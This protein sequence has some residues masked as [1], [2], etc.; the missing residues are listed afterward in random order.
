MAEVE[1]RGVGT[2][3]ALYAA[4]GWAMA[5]GMVGS[6]QA[7]LQV[8]SVTPQHGCVGVNP[9]M[10]VVMVFTRPL[11]AEA[12]FASSGTFVNAGAAPPGALT[13][14][15][16]LSL[17]S[18][19]RTLFVQLR[20]APES[21][22][23]YSL[24]GARSADGQML[25][26]PSTLAFTTGATMPS[27]SVSGVVTCP[28]SS[29][30]GTF[31]ALY[32]EEPFGGRP[33]GAIA[34]GEQ[35]YVR[36]E[37]AVCAAVVTH[38]GGQYAIDYVPAGTW[39]PLAV[40]DLNGDG[41]LSLFDDAWGFLD[42][43]LDLRPDSLVL[44]EGEACTGVDLTVA[45]VLV[46]VTAREAAQSQ[47]SVARGWAV[48]ANLFFLTGR[49]PDSVGKAWEW[50]G[51]FSSAA[52]NAELSLASV[53]RLAGYAPSPR[54]G[55]RL[56]ALPSDWVDSPVVLDS[57][58]AHAADFV[59]QAT[60]DSVV[61][62]LGWSSR[63]LPLPYAGGEVLW[64]QELEALWRVA[65]FGAQSEF[66]AVVMDA[67]SGRHLRTFNRMSLTA[68][69]AYASAAE[70]A[71]AFSQGDV[72]CCYAGAH[73]E[74]D[75]T[76]WR[77]S[78]AFLEPARRLDVLVSPYGVRQ[79]TLLAV[80]LSEEALPAGW[81]DS[82]KA[83]AAALAAGGEEFLEAHRESLVAAELLR[84]DPQDPLGVST[85]LAPAVRLAVP[86]GLLAR[87]GI[88]LVSAPLRSDTG[89][90]T[91]RMT[92]ATEDGHD[93]LLCLVDPL[94]ADV[95]Q[96][97]RHGPTTARRGLAVAQERARGWGARTT[98]VGAFSWGEEVDTTGTCGGWAYL[99]ARPAVDSCLVLVTA[100][101]MLVAQYYALS[102][103]GMGQIPAAWID[104]PE[105]I[106]KAEIAGGQAFRAAYPGALCSATLAHGWVAAF[107]N[108]T[109]WV[110]SYRTPDGGAT[111]EVVLDA[112]NGEL[113]TGVRRDQPTSHEAGQF[114]LYPAF[115][116]PS[117]AGATIKF[118]LPQQ[119]PVR[120]AVYDANG[121]LAW[122]LS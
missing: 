51:Q 73:V 112:V 36:A 106:A 11:D 33:L 111:L 103:P 24:L 92:F 38:R 10:T 99:F 107:A 13:A 18:D 98:L 22:V 59:R 50:H 119:S 94:R 75:G 46:P 31:V 2:K 4:L 62:E 70:A 115:P 118:M 17:S 96:R 97:F 88:E 35:F 30:W 15:Q 16:V 116:N 25:D 44:A 68:R 14:P 3:W 93:F 8:L 91:W 45:R 80:G 109:L 63:H 54:H 84:V 69:E 19:R 81:V 100:D 21:R 55:E 20:L 28:G 27:G 47:S 77:W 12:L 1:E 49:D 101:S 122:T 40:K 108:R 83:L 74:G 79:D 90:S 66:C 53:G 89:T 56:A 23:Q 76:A 52:Q 114:A 120:V 60:F 65:W 105:A 110:L 42:A 113:L 71:R 26:R 9:S 87:W 117:N 32:Q 72:S 29:P 43:D 67:V 78:F 95:T 7:Q 121:R 39:Y 58:R 34:R 57:A 86:E 37:Q 48:D 64:G 61:M 6:S 82:D 5:C 41:E 85:R 102:L 104:S